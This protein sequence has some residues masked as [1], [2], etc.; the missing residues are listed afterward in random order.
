MESFTMWKGNSRSLVFWTRFSLY[1]AAFK[2]HFRIPSNFNVLKPGLEI[3]FALEEAE[4]SGAKT[5]FLG[6]EF[7]T[8]T[9]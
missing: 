5:Y 2:W 8:K 9:W 7:N 1:S 3:K 6:P 4:K